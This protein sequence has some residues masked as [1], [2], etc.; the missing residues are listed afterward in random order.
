MTLEDAVKRALD[1]GL[2]ALQLREKDMPVRELIPL[3]ERMRRLA[4]RYGA[5]LFI[6]DRADVALAVDAD[7]VHLTTQSVPPG[8][9][10]SAFG[11]RLM[12]GASTHSVDE[13][14]AASGADFV[15]FGPVYDTPSKR[16]YGP[17][18]GIEW[19]HQVGRC[20]V[21]VFALGGVTIERVRE[22][23]EA[24]AFGVALI[25]D[26]LTASDITSKTASYI[27]ALS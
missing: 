2:Q 27:K 20:N 26:I 7:G 23:R 17:P 4:S 12:I 19:L 10:R 3:A 24:G 18:V 22:L 13:I 9:V 5:K 14:A 25:S 6:N 1:G 11:N 8:A 15:T 21:P 16:A